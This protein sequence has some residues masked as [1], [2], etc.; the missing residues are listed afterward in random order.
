MNAL[1]RFS[2]DLSMDSPAVMMSVDLGN[3]EPL[4]ESPRPATSWSP[5]L[6]SSFTNYIGLSLSP[7]ADDVPLVQPFSSLVQER[8]FVTKEQQLEKLKARLA[9]EGSAIVPFAGDVCKKCRDD[10]AVF[11]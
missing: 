5:R 6:F 11:L 8:R 1:R 4:E 2:D 9:T 3:R 7:K 10:D